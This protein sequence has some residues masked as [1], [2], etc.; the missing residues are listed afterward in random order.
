MAAVSPPNQNGQGLKERLAE[1]CQPVFNTRR[2]GREHR[3]LVCLNQIRQF[4]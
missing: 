4:C 1:G 2:F 3:T